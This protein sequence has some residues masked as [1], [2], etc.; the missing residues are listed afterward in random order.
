MIKK[1]TGFLILFTLILSTSCNKTSLNDEDIAILSDKSKLYIQFDDTWSPNKSEVNKSIKT[2]IEYL[3]EINK[4]DLTYK[5]TIIKKIL[6][7]IKEYRV[8]VIPLIIKDEKY[9]YLNFIPKN[10]LYPTWK[11]EQ[12]LTLDGGFR[13]WQIYY[14]VK[15]KK[16][17]R[18]AVNRNI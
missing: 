7:H 6:A 18:L 3:Y 11:K 9:I 14:N 2:A 13:F 1:Y 15:T 10:I 12:I 8:Q 16:C 5:N 17:N 4:S